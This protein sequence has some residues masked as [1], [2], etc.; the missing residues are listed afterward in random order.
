MLPALKR[1]HTRRFPLPFRPR[2]ITVQRHLPQK[3]HI[4]FQLETDQT[5]TTAVPTLEGLLPEFGHVVWPQQTGL[6]LSTV[7]NPCDDSWQNASISRD[8]FRNRRHLPAAR[9]HALSGCCDENQGRPVCLSVC[10][11]EINR[12]TGFCP[13]DHR[14]PEAR[15]LTSRLGWKNN[16]RLDYEN[17]TK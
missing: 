14:Y 3:R 10:L 8:R 11:S 17:I 5:K 4:P 1:T 13:I 7:P 15:P 12:A 2:P 16:S 9:R 6:H